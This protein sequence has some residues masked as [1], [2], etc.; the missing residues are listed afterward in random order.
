ML[1]VSGAKIGCVLQVAFGDAYPRQIKLRSR[2]VA[3]ERQA[4]AISILTRKLP[5]QQL[6]LGPKCTSAEQGPAQSMT[7]RIV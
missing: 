6:D 7:P 4:L 5:R 2:D 3:G 1:V